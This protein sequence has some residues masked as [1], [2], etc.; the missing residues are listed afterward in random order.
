MREGS[1]RLEGETTWGEL[2]CSQKSLAIPQRP[3]IPLLS[4]TW[5]FCFVFD[6]MWVSTGG[7]GNG[8]CGGH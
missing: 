5:I 2:E 3:I 6:S 1:G 8:Y 4:M 7:I